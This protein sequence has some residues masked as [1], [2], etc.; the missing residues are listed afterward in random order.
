MDGTPGNDGGRR[1]TFGEAVRSGFENYATFEGRASRSAFW[2]WVL[3][4]ILVLAGLYIVGAA[5]L[6]SM[7]LYYIGALALFLPSLAVAV[8]R[9]HDTGRSGW[10]YLIVLIPLIGSI[11]LI[12]FWVGEGDPA[13]NEYGPPPAD[14]AP[15]PAAV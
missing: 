13:D 7:V 9:L 11:I 5:V 12:V 4:Q 2:W 10:W 8:R 6:D 1:M 15:A 14:G 3:F